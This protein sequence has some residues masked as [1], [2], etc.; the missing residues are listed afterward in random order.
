MLDGQ[1]GDEWLEGARAH[2][3]DLLCRL[4]L[5]AVAKRLQVQIAQARIYG[6]PFS[7]WRELM[8]NGIRPLLPPPL[9]AMLQ[10]VSGRKDLQPP[11]IEESLLRRAGGLEPRKRWDV[12]ESFARNELRETFL[13]AHLT[14]MHEFEE[15]SMAWFGFA[16]RMPFVDRR[17]V[18]FCYALPEDQRRR[19]RTKLVLRNAM[20]GLLPEPVRQRTSKAEFSA[21]FFEALRAPGLIELFEKSRL[22]EN[23]WVGSK[24]LI[25]HYAETLRSYA[26]DGI[27]YGA[28]GNARYLWHLWNAVGLELWLRAEF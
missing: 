19:S 16:R 27:G 20:R 7:P 10:R 4:R 17:I 6:F 28:S 15:R 26:T 1:G 2:L 25:E 21:A 14:T 8:G 12:A 22:A 5:I 24:Q 18:E 3:A 9:V 13:D 23:G 11:W